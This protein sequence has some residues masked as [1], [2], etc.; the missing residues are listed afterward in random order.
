MR[1]D[2]KLSYHLLP[3]ISSSLI[4]SVA[5]LVRTSLRSPCITLTSIVPSPHKS[6]MDTM[7]SLYRSLP[8]A[9]FARTRTANFTSAQAIGSSIGVLTS[10]RVP[11]TS[12]EWTFALSWKLQQ[13]SPASPRN[14]SGWIQRALNFS[15]LFLFWLAAAWVN[16]G[17]SAL[18]SAEQ[19]CHSSLV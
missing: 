5:L 18:Q 10:S 1:R 6:L 8:L 19:R 17:R 15:F 4:L 2:C 12:R 9:A 3:C 13:S 7:K 16:P 11:T 14:L